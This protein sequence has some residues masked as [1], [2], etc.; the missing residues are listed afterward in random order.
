MWSGE[1][2]EVEG[3]RWGTEDGGLAAWGESGTVVDC[4]WHLGLVTW[5]MLG[6]AVLESKVYRLFRFFAG[7]CRC[8][9]RW[10]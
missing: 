10:N 1:G 6:W 5:V 3:E 9:R 4:W 2:S 7:G 8:V